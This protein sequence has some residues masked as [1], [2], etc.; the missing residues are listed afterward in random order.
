MW[1]RLI[2]SLTIRRNL[3]V[4]IYLYRNSYCTFSNNVV[5]A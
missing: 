1:Q 4:Y 3:K 2:V 5:G